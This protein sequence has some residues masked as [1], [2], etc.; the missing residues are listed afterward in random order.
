MRLISSLSLSDQLFDK[1]EAA[2]RAGFDG[3]EIFCEDFVGFGGTP[4]DLA[5]LAQR[6]GIAIAALQ[7]LR[8]AEGLAGEARERAFRRAGRFMEFAAAL[9]APMLLVS[10]NT[11]ADTDPD[12]ARAAADLAQLADMAAAHGLR[13]GYEPLAVSTHTRT[14]VQGWRLVKA[15]NRPNLGLVIGAIHHFAAGADRAALDQIDPARIFHVHLADA[16]VRRIEPDSLR[17]ANRVLPGQGVLPVAGLMR[18]LRGAGYGGPFSIE[19]FDAAERGLPPAVMAQDAMRALMLVEAQAEGRD[20]DPDLVGAPD[21]LHL[22]AGPASAQSAARLVAALGFAE[23]GQAAGARQRLFAQGDLGIVLEELP[24]A[25]APLRVAGIGLV[26]PDPEALRRGSDPL[27]RHSQPA[28]PANWNNPFGLARLEGPSVSWFLGDAPLVRGPYAGGLERTGVPAPEGRLTGIDHLAQAFHKRGLLSG[29]LFY[30]AALGLRPVG[31]RNVL[32]PH[33]AVY[34]YS[35]RDGA[36]RFALNLNAA[37]GDSTMTGRF[38]GKGGATPIHHVAFAC[39]GLMEMAAGL[40]AGLILRPPVNYYADL[41]LRFD[42]SAELIARLRET[43]LFYDEDAGGS[44][45]QLY[46][47]AIDGVFFE[48]VERRGDYAGF[49]AANAPARIFAQSTDYESRWAEYGHRAS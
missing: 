28:G 4:Q 24:T 40:D 14:P 12:P 21:F 34:S 17:E 9:C 10:A 32:D 5:E 48:L 30:R 19:V 20:V 45:L 2:A 36:G 26:S 27:G 22:T 3:I 15:A 46:T 8:D 43:G 11:R 16:T 35:L 1:I 41:Q 47:R 49:G 18:E 13:L 42:L 33:G 37:E 38:L 31:Q 25:D 23:M 6:E 39:T 29:L 44:Y 7:S